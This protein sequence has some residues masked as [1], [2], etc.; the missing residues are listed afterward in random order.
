M[1]A[2]ELRLVVG[3][4]ERDV[5]A[6]QLWLLG[7][8]AVAETANG[9]AAGFASDEEARDAARELAAGWAVEL[10]IDDGAWRDAWRD[11][12]EPVRVGP[13]V[14]HL[15]DRPPAHGAG[16]VA[17]VIE[18][19]PTFGSGAHPT[20]R[21]ALAAVVA[22]A[23]PGVTVLDVGSGSGVL[24]VAAAR[25]GAGPVRAVDTDP[26]AR[27]ATAA[28]ARANGVTV[29]VHEAIPAGQHDLVVANLGGARIVTELAPALAAALARGG[30]L[31]VSGL[32]HGVNA[33]PPEALAG[34]VEVRRAHLD[35]WYALHLTRP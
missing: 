9:L 7:A 23:G 34:L 21:L 4:D 20:T 30:H 15:P 18:P 14:V 19:G 29:A 33:V 1:S 35:G 27:V 32:L 5:A 6:D 12:F 13:V 25:L 28:N 31:V 26:D 11:G 17:V 8:V 2:L 16:D 24:A 10:R 3:S 22:H